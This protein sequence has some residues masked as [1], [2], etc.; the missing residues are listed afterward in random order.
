MLTVRCSE[1]SKVGDPMCTQRVPWNDSTH[2]SMVLGASGI[3]LLNHNSYILSQGE[4]RG[5]SRLYDDPEKYGYTYMVLSVP[6]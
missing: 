4:V 5:Y 3:F 6:L 2:S 1:P